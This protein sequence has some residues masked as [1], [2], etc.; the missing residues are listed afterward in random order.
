MPDSKLPHLRFSTR[1]P[2]DLTPNR[3]TRAVSSMRAARRPIL[4]L[5]LSNPTR[6]GFE[7][8]ADLLALLSDR[9]ALTY[10]PSA[11]G[12]LPA[13]E[14]VAREYERQGVAVAPDRIVLTSSSSEA[15]SLLFKLLTDAGDEVLVPRPSYPLFDHLTQLD[16]LRARPYAL[17]Y[18][19]AWS[20]DVAGIERALNARTRA[21]LVVSPNNPTGS[22][23]TEDEL[24]RIARICAARNIAVIVDEVFAD[25][26]LEGGASGRAGR[27]LRRDDVLAFSLGGLS[28]M[29]GLPQVKLGWIAASGPAP[30]VKAALD[31]LEL[32]CDTYLSVATPVQIAA[33][34]LLERGVGVRAQIQARVRANDRWL[35]QSAVGTACTVLN[36]QGG[37]Y[38]VVRVPRIAP[39]EQIVLDL[40]EA[41]A[42]L[43]HPGYFYDFSREAYLVISLLVEEESFR[44]GVGRLMRRFDAKHTSTTEDAAA[45]ALRASARRAVDP[46]LSRPRLQQVAEKPAT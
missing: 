2:S 30:L 42:I 34:Q 4:D 22:F 45:D 14:A 7:Y 11:F 20:I 12:A 9:G 3:L 8:P 13:R 32:V 10:D 43:A 23:V 21:L 31:R 41:E 24:D 6:A 38:A 36:S 19:G 18:D 37:W 1:L 15:Y 35:R 33:P 26:D 27:V 17:H 39:E 40:L 44:D 16:L 28:K 5:T 29:V 25:Y 46:D